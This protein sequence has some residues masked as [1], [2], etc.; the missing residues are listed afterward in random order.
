MNRQQRREAGLVMV[1]GVLVEGDALRIAERVH[2]YDRNLRVQYLEEAERAD[3]PPFRV[4]ERCKDG[5]ERVAFTAWT[6]DERLLQR[7]H[8]GD[9]DKH[10]L[11]R[12]ITE[13]NRRAKDAQNLRF[14]DNLAE[15]NDI[16]QHVIK[17]PKVRYTVRLNDKYGNRK[18]RFE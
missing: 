6:L 5:I 10:D 12:I 14:R 2:E 16:T 3:Q 8:A 1:G 18:V 4:V 17:S 11:D 7:I 15:A 9:N 13:A